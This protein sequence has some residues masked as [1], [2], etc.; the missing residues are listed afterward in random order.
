M[1]YENAI[2]QTYTLPATTITA[3]A[4]LLS[5]IGP[6]GKQGR[7]V[8]IGAVVTTNVTVAAAGLSVGIVGTLG[9]F[10]TLSVPISSAGAGVNGAVIADTDL[11]PV[12]A[13]TEILISSDAAATAGAAD[14]TVT[15]AW[16]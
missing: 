9:K 3:T 1:S 2:H 8:S 12:P 13:D 14:I 10:G 11:N 16:F 5:V 15:I 7:L 4:T 6:A